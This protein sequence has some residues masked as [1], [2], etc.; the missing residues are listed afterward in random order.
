MPLN[1][2]SG[3][4][5]GGIYSGVNVS[6][7][8]ELLT[9]IKDALIASDQ[10]VTDEINS[11]NRI[12]ARA[13]DRGDFCDKI[14]STEQ[15]SGTDYVLNLQGDNT[16]NGG[17]IMPP[18][19]VLKIPF[20]A[21]GN[22][23][24]YLTSDEGAEC[25]A[26]INPGA[27]SRSLHAGWLDRRRQEDKGAWAI[28]YLDVWMSNAFFAKDVHGIDWR[29]I[30][31]YYYSSKESFTSPKG[32]YQHLFDSGC[33]SMFG[34]PGT[35][36]TGTTTFNYKPWLGQT[37]SVTGLPVLLPYGYLQGAVDYDSYSNIDDNRGQ[38]LHNP[39]WIKF[40]RTGLSFMDAGDQCREGTKTFISG[41]GSGEYAYQGFQI[42]N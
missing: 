36:A 11:S 12:I 2:L 25:L 37:D 16:V 42:S 18:E 22:A 35:S 13:S 24:L 9:Q 32:P 10:T 31:T 19:K 28:G 41:G 8:F 29:E 27:E 6:S 7:S 20:I 33:A 40:A 5:N 39:G 17:T 4:A 1:F 21:N 26:I 38:G 30:Q 3:T 34:S 15:L 23:K 14:Y